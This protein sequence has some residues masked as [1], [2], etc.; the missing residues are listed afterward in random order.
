M[1]LNDGRISWPTYFMSIATLVAER[2]TCLRRKVGAV[3]IRNSRILATGYNGAPSGIPHCLDVG[4]MREKMGVPSGERHELCMAG[5]TQVKLLNG[6][7]E[8]LEAL[9]EKGE[10]FWTYACDTSGNLVP[11]LATQPRLT[12]N[13]T[14]LVKVTLDNGSSF[15]CT[16]D[17]KIML[18]NGDF[19]EAG[20]LEVG[21]SLMPMFFNYSYNNKYESVSNTVRCRIEGGLKKEY[22]GKTPST[23]THILV[24]S[25]FWGEVPKGMEIHHKNHNHLD[26]VPDNLQLM[27]KGAHVRLHNN[28][29]CRIPK[30][31]QKRGNAA[32]V[33]KIKSDPETALKFRKRGK[34]AM[35][36][37]WES[38]EFKEK[39]KKINSTNGTRTCNALNSDPETIKARMRGK[40]LKGI[41]LLSFVSGKKLTAKIYDSVRQNFPAAKK[42]LG[43]KGSSYPTV[44]TILKYFPSLEEALE[45]A[46]EYNH[47]VASVVPLEGEYPVYDVSV[48]G[49]ENF[50]IRAGD[51]SCVFAHNCMAVHAEQN[52]I[53][54]AALHGVS[55]HR[56]DV[57]C[58]H[59]P[60]FICAK[61][62]VNV[63]VKSIVTSHVYPDDNTDKLLQDADVRL[64]Y[65]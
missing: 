50:A 2:S 58:T 24:Y 4:C 17:H 64:I 49:Y 7:Y 9:A 23:P 25:H 52:L 56:S 36:A 29:K 28:G 42:K 18:R 65:L 1:A 27:E 14:D 21:T 34:A 45:A 37:L 11:A 19:E 16:K 46:S 12:G 44:K 38:S 39:M 41:S 33:A 47:K 32:A 6:T 26:N 51:D 8:S 43:E 59:K 54:Q 30:E 40:I 10:D 31:A 5:E 48:P 57:Y 22:L 35:D 55:L 62:L 53:V 61:M 3:A 63:G 13:R 60:C 20:N 15:S